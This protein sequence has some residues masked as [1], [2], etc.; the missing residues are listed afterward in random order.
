MTVKTLTSGKHIRH[1][2]RTP[3]RKARVSHKKS[4]KEII[5]CLSSEDAAELK[6]II[7][8]SCSS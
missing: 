7:E 6:N 4:I 1:S 2:I 3:I 5:G 8:Q